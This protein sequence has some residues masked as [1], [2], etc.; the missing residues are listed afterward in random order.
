[1]TSANFWIYVIVTILT[2]IVGGLLRELISSLIR[3]HWDRLRSSFVS[4]WKRLWG[5]RAGK[6]VAR[7]LSKVVSGLKWFLLL[8][9]VG[10][11]ALWG[12]FRRAVNAE[13]EVR[14]RELQEQ[15]DDILSLPPRGPGRSDRLSDDPP[16]SEEQ[17]EAGDA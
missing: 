4:R 1:M 7:A 5:T 10:F 6:A 17:K 12:S 9:P 16:W 13:V 2:I 11:G 3:R 15:I 14:I 8:L